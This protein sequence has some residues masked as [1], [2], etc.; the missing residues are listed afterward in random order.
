MALLGRR[1]GEQ[2][3]WR[4]RWGHAGAPPVVSCTG[5]S[6]FQAL[7][8]RVATAILADCRSGRH[9]L[10]APASIRDPSGLN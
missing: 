7:L 8:H 5:F 1:G 2:G 4:D 10:L 9:S 6:P 3:V